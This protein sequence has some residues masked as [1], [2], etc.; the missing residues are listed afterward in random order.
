M[1]RPKEIVESILYVLQNSNA[2]P[3]NTNFVGYEPDINSESIKLPLIEISMNLQSEINEMN[4]DFVGFRTD[5]NGNDIGEVYQ[6]DYTQ[7]ISVAVWTAHGS[8]YSPRTLSDSVRDELYEYT[9]KGPDKSLPHPDIGQLDDVWKFQIVEGEHT[10]DLGTSPTLRRWQQIVEVS[11]SERYI[12]DA[13]N[14]AA[15]EFSINE[16]TN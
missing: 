11:A 8:R 1:V 7:D 3:E 12:T 6:S 9:N 15:G 5:D 14:P 2:F 13:E 10:D 4:T 16:S